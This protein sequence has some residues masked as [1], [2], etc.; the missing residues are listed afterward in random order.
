[1]AMILSRFF[2]MCLRHGNI[3]YDWKIAYVIPIPKTGNRSKVENWRPIAMLQ[4]V[5]KLLERIVHQKLWNIVA[6]QLSRHQFAFRKGRSTE[7]QLSLLT[8][9]IQR[10]LNEG[11][12]MDVIALDL[13][14]AFDKVPHN[15]LIEKLQSSLVPD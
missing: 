4:P 5:S 8:S 15:R 11:G 3:P 2:N 13:S 10:V 1:M 9:K 14:R 6:K 12:Q 7:V